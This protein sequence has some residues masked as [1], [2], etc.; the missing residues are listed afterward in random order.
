MTED[1]VRGRYRRLLQVI[2]GVILREK[3]A[4]AANA[5]EPENAPTSSIAQREGA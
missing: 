2:E 5:G 1:E 3:I 4:R